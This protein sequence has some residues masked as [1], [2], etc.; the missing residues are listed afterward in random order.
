MNLGCSLTEI[1]YVILL[2]STDTA[3]Y[4]ANVSLILPVGRSDYTTNLDH[5]KSSAINNTVF[6]N[7]FNGKCMIGFEDMEYSNT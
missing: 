2:M 1:G 7:G 5:A 4:P 6:D 3:L